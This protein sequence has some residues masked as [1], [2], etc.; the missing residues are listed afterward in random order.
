M[1]HLYYHRWCDHFSIAPFSTE[2]SMRDYLISNP[3]LIFE[4]KDLVIAITEEKCLPGSTL[5]K[6]YGRADILLCR[7]ADETYDS[8][9]REIDISNLELWIIEL[10]KAEADFENGFIQLFDYMTTIKNSQNIQRDIKSEIIAAIKK[11]SGVD[12]LHCEDAPLTICGAVIA[13]SF[14][15]I[16]RVTRNIGVYDNEW[17]LLE[18]V[19]KQA[20]KLGEGFTL[21]DA[22]VHSRTVGFSKVTLIQLIRFKRG[23]EVVIFAENALGHRAAIRIKRFDPLLLFDNGI[24][25]ENQIYYFKDETGKIHENAKCRVLRKRGVSSSFM[26][27]I[28]SVDDHEVIQ[29]HKWAEDHFEFESKKLPFQNTAKTCSIALHKLFNVFDDTE[30]YN[31]YGNFGENNFVSSHDEKTLFELKENLQEKFKL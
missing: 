1:A 12:E 4:E 27:E 3:Q 13:P 31:N 21:L 29:I 28:L 17:K 15:L 26:I 16:E 18:Q 30:L 25:T 14:D 5:D 24:V 7:I 22:V 8:I 11:K 10:K 6:K 2:D 20:G 19:L 23:D 9:P